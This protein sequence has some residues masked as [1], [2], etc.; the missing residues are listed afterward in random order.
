M[1]CSGTGWLGYII[2]FGKF[3]RGAFA[4]PRVKDCWGQSRRAL[5]LTESPIEGFDGVRRVFY[6]STHVSF[7]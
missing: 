2:W 5:E 6:K 3:S 4:D 1:C 7:S